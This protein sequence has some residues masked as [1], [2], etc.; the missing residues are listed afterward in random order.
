MRRVMAALFCLAFTV[1][2]YGSLPGQ[3]DE[4]KPGGVIYKKKTILDIDKGIDVDGT[5]D[6]PEVEPIEGYKGRDF[7]SLIKL[8]TNFEKELL[9]SVNSL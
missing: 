2:V 3:V 6:K 9:R 5:R 8:R 4:D 7:E 1:S